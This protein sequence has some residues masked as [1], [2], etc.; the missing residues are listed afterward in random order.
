MDNHL[1]NLFS[2]IVQNRRSIYRIRK[3][4]LKDATRCQRCKDLWQKILKN[5]E[6]ETK[7]LIEVL[8]AHKF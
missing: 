4:Y 5:K 8:K 2:Q 1:Y 6:E 3:F 7:L